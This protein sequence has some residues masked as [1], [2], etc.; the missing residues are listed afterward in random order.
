MDDIQ[1]LSIVEEGSGVYNIRHRAYYFSKEVVLFIKEQKIAK[2]F[3]GMYEQLVNAATSIGANLVEGVAGA[4]KRDFIN[5]NTI[6]LKSANETKY[7]LC[8]IRDTL[9]CDKTKMQSLIN[10]ANEL[11]KIIATIIINSKK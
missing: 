5:F 11:S 9:E 3:M 10:E 8:L 4:S 2:P 7:W 1:P 6:S